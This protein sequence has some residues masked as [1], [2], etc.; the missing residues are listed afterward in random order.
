MHDDV[1][2]DLDEVLLISDAFC[3]GCLTPMLAT[4]TLQL[5]VLQMELEGA[6]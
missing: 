4:K 2:F 5:A 6:P 3:S 1:P